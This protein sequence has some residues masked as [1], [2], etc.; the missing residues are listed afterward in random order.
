[1]I[2]FRDTFRSGALLTLA[3][4]A[5]TGLSA[6][7]QE[8]APQTQAP[9]TPAE[10]PAPA[11]TPAPKTKDIDPSK[12]PDMH[13]VT[14]G[15]GARY[16]VEGTLKGFSTS[17]T[18]E[19]P[20]ST[21]NYN[22][23]SKPTKYNIGAM[24]ELR[25]TRHLSVV[26]EGMYHPTKYNQTDAYTYNAPIP[27]GLLLNSI[28]ENTSARVFDVPVMLKFRKL[29]SSGL[30]SHTF[31]TGGGAFRIVS[32]VKSSTVSTFSDSTTTTNHSP[33]GPAKR[34]A[35]GFVAGAGMRFTDE[36]GIK[37][38]PEARYTYWMDSNIRREGVNFPKS[39]IELGLS[40]SF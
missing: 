17:K 29:S 23:G 8:P 19:T 24:V 27:R 26:A 14:F 2:L 40:F 32:N 5:V 28:A 11:A 4:L 36:F 35:T 9:A 22:G 38:T 25:L 1:M 33:V 21:I 39:Q 10:T 37:V 30:L 7:T 15:I 31:L 6:Q 34:N 20:S 13:I 18:V 16:I 12:K 3:A